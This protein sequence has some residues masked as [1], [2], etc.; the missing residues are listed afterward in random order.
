MSNRWKVFVCGVVALTLTIAL[1]V[2]LPRWASFVAGL[3]LGNAA[4]CCYWL[5][6]G[7]K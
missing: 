6:E 5:W 3:I 1:S 7:D 4:V 2:V